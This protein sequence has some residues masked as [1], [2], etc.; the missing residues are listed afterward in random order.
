M[1]IAANLSLGEE[2]CPS[3]IGKKGAAHHSRTV[4]SRNR[5]IV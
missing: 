4:I 3:S 2:N 1:E 5:E